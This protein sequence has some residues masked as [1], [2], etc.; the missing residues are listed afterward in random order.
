MPSA[1]TLTFTDETGRTR[2]IKVG[3]RYFTIGRNPENNLTI[4]DANLS[5]QHALIECFD[6]FAQITDCGSQ[7]GTAVNGVTIAGAIELRD[8]DII[9]LG[10]SVDLT[11]GVRTII[12]TQSI[13]AS[14]VVSQNAPAVAISA[15]QSSASSSARW[16]LSVPFLAAMGGA[17]LVLSLVTIVLI[18]ALS[19]HRGD[20]GKK[21]GVRIDV[22]QIEETPDDQTAITPSIEETV[23]PTNENPTTNAQDS[24]NPTPVARNAE[25]EQIEDAAIEVMRRISTDP[26]D[27][28]FPEKALHDIA[29]KIETYR[30]SA[31]QLR[32]ALATLQRGGAPLAAAARREGISQPYFVFYAALAQTDGGRNAAARDPVATAQAMLPDLIALRVLFGDDAD[33]S[34][35]VIAAYPE[36]PGS[37]KSHPLLARLPRLTDKPSQR[38]VW[39][40]AERRGMSDQAYDLVIRFLALGIIAQNPK[41]YGVTAE[42][43]A[44]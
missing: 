21:R 31:S 32:D 40:L 20:K 44:F 41:R 43:L 24:L 38:N 15:S 8:G 6:N 35:L 7:N 1:I 30:A 33:S 34:L 11:V 26:K 18:V 28:S 17:I 37:K 10:G 14:S 16:W 22:A 42:P 29:Q 13:P 12:A 19:N 25:A 23:P 2:E 3:A 39:Y 5:R 27:Y 4:S 36:G 9:T